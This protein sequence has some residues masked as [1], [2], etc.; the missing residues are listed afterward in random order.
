MIRSHGVDLNRDFPDVL[1]APEGPLAAKGTEQ[2]ETCAVMA[3][4]EGVRFVGSASMHEV[5]RGLRV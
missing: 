2:A 1:T 3:W 4:S 5:R